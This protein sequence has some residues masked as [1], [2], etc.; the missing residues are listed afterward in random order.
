MYNQEGLVRQNA[1][2]FPTSIAG[3]VRCVKDD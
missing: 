2:G 3:S 1:T